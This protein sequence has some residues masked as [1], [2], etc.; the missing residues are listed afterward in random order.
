[1]RIFFFLFFFLSTALTHPLGA[2]AADNPTIGA[3]QA[4]GATS[5]DEFVEILNQTDASVAV[6]TWS[7]QYKSANGTAFYKKN[8]TKDAS[9]AAG[10]KYVV[11]GKDYAG[12]CDMKHSSFSLSSAGGTLFIVSNQTLLTSADSATIVDQKTYVAD[13]PKNE[14]PETPPPATPTNDEKQK[15]GGDSGQTAPTADSTSP[16]AVNRPQPIALAVSINEFMP[17]PADGNEWIELYNASGYAVDL[18]GWTLA[19][20]TGRGFLTLDGLFEP[21]SFKLVE[22]ASAHLNNSGDLIILRDADKK[23]VDAVAYGDW[24]S[25]PDNAPFGEPGI[26]LARIGDGRDTNMDNADF[27]ATSTPTLGSANIITAPIADKNQ[28]P[29]TNLQVKSQIQNPIAK[30]DIEK[31]IELLQRKDKIIIIENLTINAGAES[32]LAAATVAPTSKPVAVKTTTK[33]LASTTKTAAKKAA[34]ATTE[35]T[36]IVPPGIVGKDICV[37]RESDRSVEVRL[38]KDIKTQPIAGDVIK[39]SGAWSTAK[40]L[41]LPRLL[42][43]TAVAFTISGH[44]DPPEPAP[45]AMSEIENRLGELVSVEAPIVEKQPTRFRLAESDKAVLIKAQLDAM[46]GDK[47]SASGLLVKNNSDFQLIPFSSADLKVIKPP[48]PSPPSLVRKALPY[49]IAIVPA[50]LIATAAYVGKKIKKKKTVPAE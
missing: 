32:K 17:D 41:S 26:A 10:G 4:S 29:R 8:F 43:K 30:T 14:T 40:T 33:T 25:D 3:I 18:A 22:L 13:P 38:P 7:I 20:G 5:D 19:D 11:C 1:M 45:I 23:E 27:A 36:I 24:E 47:V 9:V 15:D 37:V 34:A 39:A 46:R 31:L 42:V 28:E 2:F 49:G 6:G 21:Q 50:G 48:A 44:T 12:T 16:L 35:G